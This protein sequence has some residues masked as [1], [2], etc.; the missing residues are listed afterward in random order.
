MGT[1]I[2]MIIKDL[3]YALDEQKIYFNDADRG[4]I[5]ALDSASYKLSAKQEH[6]AEVIWDK[7][8]KGREDYTKWNENKEIIF[9]GKLYKEV[10][11]EVASLYVDLDD[12][13]IVLTDWER[14]FI[15]DIYTKYH[16]DNYA[17]NPRETFNPILTERQMEHI[18]R[19]HEQV[20]K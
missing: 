3:V 4:F 11:E 10:L 15:E 12:D 5:E 14:N 13:D 8:L 20:D 19:I 9:D 2:S 7:R 1:N 18:G 17:R 6:A 16:P